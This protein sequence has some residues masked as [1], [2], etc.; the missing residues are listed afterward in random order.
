MDLPDESDDTELKPN[1]GYFNELPVGND[2]D[3]W[4][5]HINVKQNI[6]LELNDDNS[7]LSAVDFKAK[8]VVESGDP[9]ALMAFH[10]AKGHEE[11]IGISSHLLGGD[12]ANTVGRSPCSLQPRSYLVFLHAVSTGYS[13]LARTHR[14]DPHHTRGAI[15]WHI[16]ATVETPDA[17]LSPSTILIYSCRGN[18]AKPKNLNTPPEKKNKQNKQNNPKKRILLMRRLKVPPYGDTH[19]VILS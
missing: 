9:T 11:A 4:Y 18:I 3:G 1:G 17:A 6:E 8:S 16:T 7:V 5:W 12:S 14:E 10:F 13:R 2:F 15:L 19:L